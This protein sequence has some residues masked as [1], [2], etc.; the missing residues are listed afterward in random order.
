MRRYIAFGTIAVLVGTMFSAC[1]R[2]NVRTDTTQ[3]YIGYWECTGLVVNGVDQ[4]DS[5]QDSGIPLYTFYNLTLGNDNKGTLAS[6]MSAFGGDE[7]EIHY[8]T[9]ESDE[10]GVDLKGDDSSDNLRLS[11]EDGKLVMSES[12]DGKTLEVYFSKV[13]ELSTFDFASWAEQ[14][15]S[16]EI[17][18][19]E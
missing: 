15:Y 3:Q 18:K 10:N 19:G 16:T 17:S 4:G 2:N 11:S 7:E 8:F 12:N 14:S 6:P 1:G 9:W 5:F 13:D